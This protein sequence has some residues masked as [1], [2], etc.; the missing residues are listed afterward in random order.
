VGEAEDVV[1][2]AFLR[3]LDADH[4]TVREPEAFL[5]AL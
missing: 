1:Q 5:V 3:W 4:G 2:D